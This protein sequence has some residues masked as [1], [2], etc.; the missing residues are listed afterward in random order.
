MD[1]ENEKILTKLFTKNSGVKKGLLLLTGFLIIF[2]CLGIIIKFRPLPNA[3]NLVDVVDEEVYAK[4]EI[5]GLTDYFA[6]YSTED[7]STNDKY[8]L[9]VNEDRIY[10]LELNDRQYEEMGTKLDDGEFV[11]VYGMTENIPDELK[12]IAIDTLKEISREINNEELD[13]D[14]ENFYQYFAAYSLDAKRNPNTF[15]STFFAIA[16]ML[17][18][19][20]FVYILVY[21]FQIVKTKKNIKVFS[22]KYDLSTLMLELD[23]VEKKEYKKA[24]TIMT[25]DFLISYSPTLEIMKYEDI[26]WMYQYRNKINGVDSTYS[27]Y[28]MLTDKKIHIISQIPA[29]GKDRKAEYDEIYS[30][31]MAKNTKMLCGYTNENIIATKKNN[32]DETIAKMKEA[33][34]SEE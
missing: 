31:I 2:V 14:K 28:V 15:G 4:V 24:K 18:I 1:K 23:D 16:F 34:K 3:Q 5:S 9:G 8:Y 13:V 12:N 20:T 10:I 27:I 17:G 29:S 22:N 32:I 26:V 7:K 33:Q 11:V 21:I 30:N 25:K 6:T 19:M